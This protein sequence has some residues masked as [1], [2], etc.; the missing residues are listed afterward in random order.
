MQL[1]DSLVLHDTFALAAKLYPLDV[2]PVAPSMVLPRR[3][4]SLASPV[5]AI[6]IWPDLN[7]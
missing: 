7:S 6:C 1:L 4:T 3:C 2:P 5:F